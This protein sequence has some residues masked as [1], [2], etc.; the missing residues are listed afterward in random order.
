MSDSFSLFSTHGTCT[1]VSSA[2]FVWVSCWV[3]D[4]GTAAAVRRCFVTRSYLFLVS[5][6]C[7]RRAFD[8]GWFFVPSFGQVTQPPGSGASQSNTN[9]KRQGHQCAT[10][11]NLEP[12][13]PTPRAYSLWRAVRL[14]VCWIIN[15]D[16]SIA[17]PRSPNQTHDKRPPVFYGPGRSVDREQEPPSPTSS[18]RAPST[19]TT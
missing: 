14:R 18:T 4:A 13:Q 3:V 11:L 1:L 9:R 19:P 8:G 7:P 12:S 6:S 5:S 2:C 15:P 17:A 10:A 16:G